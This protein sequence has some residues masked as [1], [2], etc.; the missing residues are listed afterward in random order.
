MKIA[1]YGRTVIVDD[2][3][4]DI[5]DLIKV[6]SKE[7]ISTTYF[8]GEIEGLP[9]K[10]IEGV[11]LLFLDLELNKNLGSDRDKAS[12]DV[13]VIKTILGDHANDGTVILVVWTS[14]ISAYDELKCM[15][16]QL[17]MRFLTEVKIEKREC[18]TNSKFDLKKIESVLA[19]ALD[20]LG[21]LD[22]INYWDNK[23]NTAA[24][25]VYEKII[26]N[27]PS[28]HEQLER[29]INTLYLKMVEAVSGKNQDID[30][31]L[32]V[33]R[34]LNGVL[35]NEICLNERSEF[36]YKIECSDLDVL[37]LEKIGV[38]NSALNLVPVRGEGIPGMVYKLKDNI[39]LNYFEIFQDWKKVQK[40]SDFEKKIDIM[41]EVTPLCDYAQKRRKVYRF[42]LGIMIPVS[43]EKSL[44]TRADYI[45]WTPVFS[46][47]NVFP[48]PFII[49]F[50]LR[51]LF[52]MGSSDE[53]TE[54]MG[55]QFGENLLMHI[56]NR[57]GRQVSNPGITSIR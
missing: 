3:M 29:H 27:A 44:K 54:C 24:H 10:P 32:D 12:Q 42:L 51:F 35:S 18:K 2:Q 50:D 28:N 21:S 13:K 23:I 37:N 39:K 6:L 19:S 15:I 43:L 49:V 36:F 52:T 11:S 7:G 40:G 9:T 14:A 46:D 47:G 33:E 4:E 48:E 22:L 1:K 45:Y 38:F 56:Q 17:K 31:V 53:L 57:L 20:K 41:C 16:T 25:K 30:I 34:V 55:L 26:A 5:I 8:T